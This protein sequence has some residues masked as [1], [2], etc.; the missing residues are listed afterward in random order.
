MLE[1]KYFVHNQFEKFVR[2]FPCFSGMMNLFS[3]MVLSLDG[4]Y[5][6]YF[7]LFLFKNEY[8]SEITAVRKL[9]L[10]FLDSIYLLLFFFPL[11][12][13]SFFPL[14]TFLQKKVSRGKE[15]SKGYCISLFTTFF[16]RKAWK[17][18]EKKKRGKKN[19]RR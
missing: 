18:R 15:D 17:G 4:V 3:S 19:S 12:L 14:Q 13:F 8:W 11:I 7:S 6:L 2:L 16:R 5:P 10:S 9:I 1:E